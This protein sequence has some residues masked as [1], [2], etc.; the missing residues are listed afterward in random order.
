MD[1]AEV[2]NRSSLPGRG[3]VQ[4]AAC[5]AGLLACVV[6]ANLTLKR[7]GLWSIGPFMV[8]SGAVWA[9]V[10][11]TL[12]DG[13]HETIGAAWVLFA[14][15]A[16]AALS[17]FVDPGLAVAS[18]TAFLLGELFD[19]AVYAPLRQ[20]GRVRA[21][22]ASNLVGSIVDSVVFLWLAPFPVTLN[23]VAGLVLFKLAVT[24]AFGA[25]W[26]AGEFGDRLAGARWERMR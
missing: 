9:G 1:A 8:A 15:V 21:V 11:L 6:L 7:F 14:I 4:G 16:G 20:Q 24:A 18:G 25:V 26:L 23:A 22:A 10:A 3:R 17:A 13:I 5:F 19:F 12:R 2:S